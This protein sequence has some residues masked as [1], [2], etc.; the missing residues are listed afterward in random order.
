MNII[1]G[2][3]SI[4]LCFGT[5]VVLEKLFKKEGLYIWIS[6]ATIIANILVCK[7][8]NVIGFTSSLG[9][10]MFASVFLATDIMTEKYGTEHSKKAVLLGMI[11]AI[12]FVVS[13]QISLLYI[14]DTTDLAQESMKNLFGINLRTSI[15]SLTMYFISN[16]LGIWIFEKIKKKFPNKLW[17]RNN[18]STI[19]ANCSENYCFAFIAF[20]GI[21][22]IQVI[23][24]IAT[25]G[26][27]LEIL[28]AICDTPFLYIATKNKT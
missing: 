23:L 19:I 11:S 4:I 22:D 2:I 8:I 27:I 5:I 12:I 15:A 16:I 17:L 25:V 26:S 10:I 21:L 20:L 7:T 18:V 9:N 24:S 28:I 6:I 1:L 14:P 3:I 13:T